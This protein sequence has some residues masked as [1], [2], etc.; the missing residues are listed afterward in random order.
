MGHL[1]PGRGLARRPSA[2]SVAPS[3]ESAESAEPATQRPRRLRSYTAHHAAFQSSRYAVAS[4]VDSH[5]VFSADLEED[6]AS[7]AASKW[8]HQALQ[9]LAKKP[10]AAR[11]LL[12]TSSS[13]LH[14]LAARNDSKG[15]KDALE[16][17]AP[18][19]AQMFVEVCE[20]TFVF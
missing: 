3:A 17:Q 16:G 5:P 18:E 19:L 10:L 8:G 11:W 20:V 12:D 6:T 15:L 13:E 9:P 4:T 2:W 7:R 14:Q 1:T